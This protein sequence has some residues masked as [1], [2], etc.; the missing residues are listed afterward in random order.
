MA[1]HH[2]ALADGEGAVAPEGVVAG[3]LREDGT[4]NLLLLGVA[5][6]GVVAV[7]ALLEGVVAEHGVA[8]ALVFDFV[9]GLGAVG[10]AL[11]AGLAAGLALPDLGAAAVV[12]VGGRLGGLLLGAAVGVHF[13]AGGAAEG[14]LFADVRVV[15]DAPEM[16][17]TEQQAEIR[18]VDVEAVVVPRAG[19]E[20][21]GALRPVVGEVVVAGVV[22]VVLA[23]GEA[24]GLQVVDAGDGAGLVL[25][26]LE[27]REEHGRED[28]DDRDHDEQFN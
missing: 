7:Q 2:D 22:V 28:C 19:V 1:V 25:G 5:V 23:H 16:L 27:G 4:V 18:L 10:V 17:F 12:A 9:A 15:H 13:L 6:E 3:L 14:A 8:G 24:D 11:A 26:L 21:P 20:A